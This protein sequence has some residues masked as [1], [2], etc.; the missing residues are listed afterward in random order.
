MSERLLQ[1]EK[2]LRSAVARRDYTKVPE[3]AAALGKQSAEE[4]RAFP[5]GDPRAQCIFDQLQ[6]VLEWARRMVCVARASAGDDLQRALM[7]HRYLTPGN[8]SGVRLRFDI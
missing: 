7:A 5:P 1:L 2:D 3:I 8:K 6:R 4:W